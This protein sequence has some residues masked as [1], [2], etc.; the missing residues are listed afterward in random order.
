MS[1][2]QK[3]VTIDGPSGVGK[4]T[5]SRGVAERLGFVYMDTGAMYRAVAY[6]LLQNG[7]M[8]E[9]GA[10]LEGF[11][12][13]MTME[14]LPPFDPEGD[15]RVILN[16]EKLGGLIRTAEM[17]MLAS[18]ISALPEVRRTLTA[19]Q[20]DMGCK[21]KVVAE[22]RD[23]GTVVFPAAAWKFYLDAD[24]E[25][26]ARRRIEQLKESG[27]V[28]DEEEIL[29]QLIKRDADDSSRSLAPLKIAEDALKIDCTQLSATDVIGLMVAH[30]KGSF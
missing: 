13:G 1:E 18:R 6:G 28:V 27:Q 2:R 25:E 3:I 16:G 12:E 11:L 15:V 7:I 24:P 19:L 5:V 4:S 9:S 26:R 30:V 8:P 21:G 14:L 22:G 23:T 10:P 29:H 20:Q 17:G